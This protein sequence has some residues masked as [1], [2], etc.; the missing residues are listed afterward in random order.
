MDLG[1]FYILTTLLVTAFWSNIVSASAG[2][3]T[4]YILVSRHTFTVP[5]S[6]LRLFGFALWYA[7]S[8]ICFSAIIKYLI[9]LTHWQPIICKIISLPF[10][11]GVNYGFSAFYFQKRKNA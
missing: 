1:L 7:F 2:V 6:L 8:I 11:F 9:L 10:S 5:L 4:T 3:I